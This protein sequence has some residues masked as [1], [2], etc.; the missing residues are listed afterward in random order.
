MLSVVRLSGLQAVRWI[1]PRLHT[2]IGLANYLDYLVGPAH[3]DNPT[4]NLNIS[5]MRLSSDPV[6]EI[7]PSD[8][9]VRKS[10]IYPLDAKSLTHGRASRPCCAWALTVRKGRD[11]HC[12]LTGPG[13]LGAPLH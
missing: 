2:Y 11:H 7:P 9:L 6:P 12:R 13:Q 3:A 5:T 1:Q 4:A 10:G 8:I